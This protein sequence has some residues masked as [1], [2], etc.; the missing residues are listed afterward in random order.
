MATE[1]FVWMGGLVHTI[2]KGTDCPTDC[3]SHRG[4][5]L[6]DAAAKIHHRVGRTSVMPAATA[7]LPDTQCGRVQAR[8]ADLAARMIRGFLRLA[9][10]EQWAATVIFVDLKNAFH[11]VRRALV[12]TRPSLSPE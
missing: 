2:Y 5:V 7:P 10:Q 9:K 12:L 6:E 8:G 3:N 4:V 1:P 11:S